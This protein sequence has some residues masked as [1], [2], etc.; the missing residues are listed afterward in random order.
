M[1]SVQLEHSLTEINTS[2]LQKNPTQIG[3]FGNRDLEMWVV[4]NWSTP[5]PLLSGV[6]CD[7]VHVCMRVCACLC[8]F[9]C[10][11]MQTC[12]IPRCVWICTC[13]YVC[14]IEIDVYSVYGSNIC[15]LWNKCVFAE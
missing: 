3:F 9:V 1:G 14:K 5:L 15:N 10:A 7:F 2:F 8:V 4:Y 12:E 11:C 6:S 13:V